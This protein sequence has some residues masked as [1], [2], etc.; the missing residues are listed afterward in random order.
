MPPAAQ[1]QAASTSQ[2]VESASK[3]LLDDAALQVFS[4]DV[5]GILCY[6]S[7]TGEVVC[8]GLDEG[9]HFYPP[10]GSNVYIPDMQAAAVLP[11]LE[12]MYEIWCT[13]E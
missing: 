4:D 3:V 9:P 7:E 5:K 1:L 8:E 10:S 12:G 2:E 13:V 11:I 6:R